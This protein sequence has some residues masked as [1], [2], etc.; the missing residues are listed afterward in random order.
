MLG[1]FLVFSLYLPNCNVTFKITVEFKIIIIILESI[2]DFKIHI[3]VG[4][5]LG[6]Y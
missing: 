2:G 4:K 6:K 5:I 3:K 1:V